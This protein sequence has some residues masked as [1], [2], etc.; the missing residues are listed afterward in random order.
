MLFQPQ[1]KNL[2]QEKAV[3]HALVRIVRDLSK[4]STSKYL[5]SWNTKLTQEIYI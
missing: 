1:L 3:K 4:N 2:K 5:L